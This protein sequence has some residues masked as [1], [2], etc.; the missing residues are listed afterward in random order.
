MTSKYTLQLV[1]MAAL[2]S[3]AIPVF[4]EAP[5]Y[6]VDQLDQDA[7]SQTQHDV[8]PPSPSSPDEAPG[9]ASNQDMQPT[10]SAAPS[11]SSSS[12]SSDL[13][14]RLGKIEQQVNDLTQN[15]SAAQVESLQSQIQT[16]RNQIEQLTHNLEKVQAEQKAAYTDVDSRLAELSSA[17]THA[18]SPA[19][20]AVIPAKSSK[21]ADDQ[22]KVDAAAKTDSKVSAAK[23]D[24]PDVAEEQQIYQTAYSLIKDKKYDDAVKTLQNMLKKYPSGQFASNAHYWLGELYGLLGKSDKSLGEFVIVVTKYNKSPR[25]SDAQLK[26]GTIFANQQKWSDAKLAFKKVIDKYPGTASARLASEQLKQLKIAG[27]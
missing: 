19:I 18:A 25:I 4:A 10:A 6:E 8:L 24:G 13:S 15:S 20:A 23:S 16:L 1:L 27:H 21:K 22:P 9:S 5:V 14:H 11:S 7:P 12:S 26:I 3:A 2:L 17:P